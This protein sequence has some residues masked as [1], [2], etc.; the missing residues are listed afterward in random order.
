MYASLMSCSNASMSCMLA[1]DSDAP[2]M[3]EKYRSRLSF[4]KADMHTGQAWQRST[5]DD[6]INYISA[7][8]DEVCHEYRGSMLRHSR[9]HHRSHHR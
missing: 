7:F 5:D 8:A 4:E 6:N 1:A 2:F 3:G 9:L